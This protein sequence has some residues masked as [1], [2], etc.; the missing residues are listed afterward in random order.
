MSKVIFWSP[1]STRTGSTHS[2]I[3]IS[4]LTG[5]DNKFSSI[6]LQGHWQNKVIES[7]F[8]PYFDLKAMDAFTN[9]N[10]GMSA[11]TRLIDSNKLSAEGIKNYAKPI[12]KN[13]LDVLYGLN[14]KEREAY[15][16]MFENMA[17]VLDRADDAYDVVFFDSPKGQDSHAVTNVLKTADIIVVTVSQNIIDIDEFF[18]RYDEIQILKEKKH[19]IVIGD[20]VPTS[21]YTAFNLKSK[22]KMKVPIYTIPNCVQF[23]DAVNDGNVVDFLFKN[24]KASPRDSIGYFISETRKIE[25]EILSQLNIK[26]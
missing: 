12:L 1:K 5:I 15:R 7:A 17:Y 19:I 14:V 20:Y 4:A 2:L 24:L 18:S 25:E 16:K 8:T 10:I 13:R 26:E 6:I 9:S 11:L 3:A 22:Y 23:R 21:K